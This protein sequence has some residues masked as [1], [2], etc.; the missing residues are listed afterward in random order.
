MFRRL[1]APNQTFW[2]HWMAKYREVQAWQGALAMAL[3]TQAPGWHTTWNVITGVESRKDERGHFQHREIRRAERR[4]VTVIRQVR[5]RSHFIRDDDNLRF[6][7][8]P[9]NDALTRAGLLYDDSREWLEQGMPVQE[10]S[11]DRQ[12]R[13]IVRI[14]RVEGTHAA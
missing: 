5:Q 6:A 11:P 9:L 13:T 10:V 3:A 4:R 1:K 8:K 2:A 14:E 7:V 12:V